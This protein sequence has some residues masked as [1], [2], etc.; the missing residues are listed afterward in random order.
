MKGIE[1]LLDSGNGLTRTGITRRVNDVERE[2]SL[3]SAPLRETFGPLPWL[4]GGGS[5]KPARIVAGPARCYDGRGLGGERSQTRDPGGARR[6]VWLLLLNALFLSVPAPTG[7]LVADLDGSGQEFTLDW[8][9]D[10]AGRRAFIV[11]GRADSAPWTSP[12]YPSWRVAAGKIAADAPAKVVL[13]AWTTRRRH[14]GEG[15]FR[16]IW[17]LGWRAGRLQ[18]RWRG[19]ALARPFE[20]FRLADLDGDGVA[21]LLVFETRAAGA[22][23]ACSVAAYRWTGFGFAGRGR[24]AIPCVGAALCD[25]VPGCVRTERGLQRARLDGSR[26]SL[27]GL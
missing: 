20:D 1:S 8:Y 26:L 17:V 15:P 16:S 9:A 14:P 4:L 18:M 19:S 22:A 24:V 12:L 25:D 27:T 23:A 7:R 11:V 2:S 3:V 21:E 5:R 6:T 10:E 13:G